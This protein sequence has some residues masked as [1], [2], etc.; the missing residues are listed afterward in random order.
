MLPSIGP[1]PQTGKRASNWGGPTHSGREENTAPLNSSPLWPVDGRRY[2]EDDLVLLFL[3]F[4]RIVRGG[5]TATPCFDEASF[6]CWVTL[7]TGGS[8]VT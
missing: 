7:D 5:A 3:S 4:M 8:L 2:L 6:L 1:G